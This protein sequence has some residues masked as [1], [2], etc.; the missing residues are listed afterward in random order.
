M[1]SILLYLSFLVPISLIIRY[2]IKRTGR[3]LLLVSFLLIGLFLYIFVG[4]YKVIVLN[5][6]YTSK[7]ILSLFFLFLFIIIIS[8]YGLKFEKFYSVSFQEKD[9]YGISFKKYFVLSMLLLLGS[10]YLFLL[11]TSRHGLPILF[12]P[13]LLF[14]QDVYKLRA[15]KWTNLHEGTSWYKLGFE[16]IPRI[17]IVFSVIVFP[18]IKGIRR[19]FIFILILSVS[20]ILLLCSLTKSPIVLS[21]FLAF[22][23]YWYIYNTKIKISTTL[24]SGA[25]FILLLFLLIKVYHL[26]RTN[27]EIISFL[28][29]IVWDR[30]TGSYTIALAKILYIF[31][32]YHDFHYGASFSNPFGIFPYNPINISQFLGDWTNRRLENDSPPSFAIGYANFDF[33]GM[34]IVLI[35]IFFIVFYLQKKIA[36]VKN[37]TYIY[38]T[39]YIM[40]CERM[41]HFSIESLLSTINLGLLFV[42]F[43]VYLIDITYNHFFILKNRT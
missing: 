25:I 28:P 33:I 38:I 26:D 41:M 24:L 30:I 3:K 23:T 27:S 43:I 15:E 29:E 13:E 21:F 7:Y 20:F 17:I 8:F 18:Q 36:R 1:V 35:A 4:S 19:W 2:F 9:Y 11:Y 22:L 16:S 6:F 14:F 42:F 32:N 12:N 5:E 37:S 10:L 31:P 34:I 40:Y 39:F